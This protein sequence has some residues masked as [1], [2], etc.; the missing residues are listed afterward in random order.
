[1]KAEL[2]IK[3]AKST[4]Y[5]LSFFVLAAPPLFIYNKMQEG[6]S[7]TW[8]S[9]L[10]FMGLMYILLLPLIMICWVYAWSLTRRKWK[11]ALVF[12][13]LNVIWS[14][15]VVINRPIFL[16]IEIVTVVLLLQGIL[17]LRKLQRVPSPSIPNQVT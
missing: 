14:I 10:F 12:F 9:D 3:T 4:A 8:Q 2:Q 1:M 16:P 11:T 15:L 5:V 6:E 7:G 13:I 17:G